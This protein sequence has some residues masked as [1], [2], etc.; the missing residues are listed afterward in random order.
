M[1]EHYKTKIRELKRNKEQMRDEIAQ[2]KAETKV[3]LK[4]LH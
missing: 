3:L 2:S 4:D 1:K